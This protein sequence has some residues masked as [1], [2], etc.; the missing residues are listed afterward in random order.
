MCIRD[1]AERF[2]GDAP[3]RDHAHHDRDRG[4]RQHDRHDERE[5]GTHVPGVHAD[6]PEGDQ[7]HHLATGE[8]ERAT[9]GEAEQRADHRLAG[10]DSPG[11][12]PV[13]AD[14]PEGGQPAVAALTAEAHRGAEED[15]D[16]Q[17]EHDESD[18]YQES[19][20][21]PQRLARRAVAA[22]RVDP[23]HPV[24]GKHVAVA[25]QIER[26]LTG[27]GETLVRDRP[28]DARAA[29]PGGEQA[30]VGRVEQLLQRR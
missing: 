22:E 11:H 16:G 6:V 1:S 4:H 23:A 9:G 15:R 14:Q 29:Q 8:E 12:P 24:G 21:R 18:H 25:A 26:E 10:G 19:E 17:Q 2:D 3:Q 7:W 13:G 5:S 30:T 20:G 28:D 27:T